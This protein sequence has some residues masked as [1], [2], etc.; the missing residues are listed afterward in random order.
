[1]F[2]QHGQGKWVQHGELRAFFVFGSWTTLFHFI[3]R[4]FVRVVLSVWN[5]L[6]ASVTPFFILWGL[7]LNVILLERSTSSKI[8]H[9]LTLNLNL[10]FFLIAF[11]IFSFICLQGYCCLCFPHQMSAP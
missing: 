2:S 11:N 6:T 5:A 9:L 7:S 4:A 1:M 10:F 8:G 3:M